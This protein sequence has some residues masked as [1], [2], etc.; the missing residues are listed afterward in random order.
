MRVLLCLI[1]LVSVLGTSDGRA[2]DSH[3]DAREAL[4]EGHIAPL[5]QILKLLRARGVGEILEVELERHHGRWI[6]E[7]EALSRD[8]VISEHW[9]D[10]ATKAP[11]PLEPEDEGHEQVK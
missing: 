4:A 8:G 11:L 3:D 2:A 10:A 1:A 7:I 9:V 6:Y 5:D